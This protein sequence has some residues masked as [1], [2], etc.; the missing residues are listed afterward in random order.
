M[1]ATLTPIPLYWE[2]GKC[3]YMHMRVN[4][5]QCAQDTL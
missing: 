5:F 1:Q 3:V 4:S 2:K